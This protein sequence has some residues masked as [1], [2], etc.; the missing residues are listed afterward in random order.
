MGHRLRSGLTMATVLLLA[1]LLEHAVAQTYLCGKRSAYFLKIP[2]GY[3]VTSVKTIAGQNSAGGAAVDSAN[4]AAVTFNTSSYSVLDIMYGVIY[5]S[6]KANHKIRAISAAGV[7][8]TFAGTGTASSVDN[9]VGLSATFNL[10]TG[11]AINYNARVMYVAGSGENKIRRVALNGTNAVVEYAGSG[12]T[13][14]TDT[15]VPLNAK[16]N[17]PTGLAYDHVG[18][19]LYIADTGNSRIRRMDIVTGA[20]TKVLDTVILS[21]LDVAFDPITNALYISDTGNNAVVKLTADTLVASTIATGVA[22][23][24]GISGDFTNGLLFVTSRSGHR[25]YSMTMAGASVTAIA[26]S[27]AAGNA[28]SATPTTATFNSPTGVFF[29]AV[30]GGLIVTDAGG[31]RLRG[32]IAA[33]TRCRVATFTRTYQ[34]GAPTPAPTPAPPVHRKTNTTTASATATSSISMTTSTSVSTT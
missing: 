17:T 21:A 13:G 26:G 11:L 23:P 22:D 16:F 33:S 24:A 10:P 20:V 1:L 15:P 14:S 27:G 28:D 18:Q 7:T 5:V 8:T 19:K 6:D 29:D 30:S 12:L 25:V 2:R 4:P 31:H 32:M 9:A 34:L 3:T